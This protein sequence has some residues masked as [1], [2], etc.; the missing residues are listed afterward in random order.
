ME[1]KTIYE[2]TDFDSNVYMKFD[3]YK[4]ALDYYDVISTIYPNVK[5]LKHVTTVLL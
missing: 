2:V 5:L 1:N 4:E 3:D